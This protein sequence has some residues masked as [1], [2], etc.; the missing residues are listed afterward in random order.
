MRSIRR[1]LVLLG[2]LALTACTESRVDPPPK[3]VTTPVPDVKPVSTDAPPGEKPEVAAVDAERAPPETGKLADV[4]QVPMLS[5]IDNYFERTGSSPYGRRD[6]AR[7]IYVQVDKAMYQPGESIWVKSWH[8]TVRGLSPSDAQNASYQLVSPKGAVVEERQV[9]LASGRGHHDFTLPEG[10]QGGEYKI[11]VNAADGTTGERPIIVNA[12]EA[13]RIKKKLEFVRKAYGAGDEVQA[14]LEIK[15]PT[16]E[17]LAN[18]AVRGRIMLDGAALDDVTMTTDAKGAGIVKMKLP[19]EIE[20][21]DGILTVFIEDGGVTESVSKRVPIVTKKLRFTMFPEGGHPVTGLETRVYFEAKNPLGKPADVEGHVVDTVGNIVAKFASHWGGLGRFTFTPGAGETYKV[22]ITKPSGI[23]DAYPLP[24]AVDDGCVLRTYDDP[25]GK[26]QA[27]RARVACTSDK[28]VTLVATQRDQTFAAVALDV[29]AGTPAVAH[30]SSTDKAL[31]RA[32]GSARITVLDGEQPIAER[33]VFRNRRAQMKV[34]ITPNKPAYQPRDQVALTVKT[35]DLD[36]NPLPSELALSIVDDTVVSFADDKTGHMLAKLLLEPELPTEVE[37]PN[38]FFDLTEERSALALEMLMGTKGWRKFDWVSALRTPE[39]QRPSSIADATPERGGGGFVDRMDADDG[40]GKA[41]PKGGVDKAAPQKM[42]ARPMAPAM[43]APKAAVPRGVAP[44]QRAMGEAQQ[45]AAPPAPPPPPAVRQQ[46]EVAAA[47]PMADA[48][49]GARRPMDMP[50]AEPVALALERDADFAEAKKERAFAAEEVAAP[51][52]RAPMIAARVFPAPDYGG[53]AVTGPRTDFRETIFWAPQVKTGRD[54]I[55]TVTF[56]LSD[57][58][59]SFRVFAEGMAPGHL[60]RKERVISSALPFSM[61]IKLPL[62][63]SAG[64]KIKAPVTFTNERAEN[65]DVALTTSFGTLLTQTSSAK[66]SI[67]LAAKARDS[68]FFELDVTGAKGES[69][70]VVSADAAGLSDAFTRKLRVEP[71]G[72]PVEISFA[73]QVGA[74]AEHTLEVSDVEKGTFEASVKLYPSPLSTM[75]S[76]LEG[77]LRQPTGC[78]EQASSSNYPNVMILQHIQKSGAA[79][80]EIVERA[81]KL[82]D[83]GYK[84]LTGYE[85]ANKGY[86]WFGGDPGH[87]ALS[88]YGLLEFVDM[89]DVYGVDSAMIDRT[90]AWLMQRRD[91]SGGYQR[92]ARALDSFGS[93]SPDVTNAYI[94]YSL[95]EAGYAAQVSKEID[96]LL[97][98]AQGSNDAYIVALAANVAARAKKSSAKSLV[99]KLA[100]LMETNGAFTKADH[101]I[102]RSS[103]VNLHTETTAL[104]V[105]A[106]L[107]SETHLDKARK[108]VEWLSSN[109]QGFGNWGA[110]QATI[111][112]IK[113]FTK[114]AEASRAAK[115]PGSVIVLVNGKVAGRVSYEAGHKDALT[116][117]LDGTHLKTGANVIRLTHD[118]KGELPYSGVI[119]YR[120]KKPPSAPDALVE[121]STTIDKTTMKM[122][123]TARVWATVKNKTAAGL[124]MTLARVGLPGGL[125]FQTWQLKELREKGEIAF[126]ETRPR[127]VILYLRHM[128]PNEEKKIPIDLVA[129]VPGEYTGPASQAYLYYTDDKRVWNDAF[130]VVIEP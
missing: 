1:S 115:S 18:H 114:Y 82:L 95:V 81:Q 66:S 42:A 23:T 49:A 59:T 32:I 97:R 73:G 64:D 20:M 91:G 38:F 93:A 40:F 28:R 44:M 26:E 127:E 29:K 123:D 83:D 22:Q 102:T 100:K 50:M 72:F 31:A 105:L 88:A 35:S 11:R 56:F 8:T 109:R 125:T 33:V 19:R 89:R 119:T 57:A 14:T 99:D 55:A 124:P 129:T 110:T 120:T 128:A 7:R 48:V 104:A 96:A 12:Y 103:G 92:N 52:R 94:T 118:G 37:E 77:M 53:V 117:V 46:N 16:G 45:G 107:Q 98:T 13:P 111:L 58:I 47:K 3:D 4:D 34:D 30:L 108:G 79:A 71:T 54:G 9:V 63:V 106:F 6:G 36:G 15:R 24:L 5:R 10:A 70:I 25:D 61:A 112:A 87:E 68:S 74:K 62:E 21:G 75:V 85:S 76:G 80:P 122:G 101:S 60:G 126:W 86:E 17:S 130:H 67:S 116:V 78:F 90:A 41:M 113:A 51:G 39:P 121:L 2:L 43:P 84:R 69:E 65:L 27:I